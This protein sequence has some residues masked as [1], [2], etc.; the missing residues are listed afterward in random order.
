MTSLRGYCAMVEVNERNAWR[1]K[2]LDV[3]GRKEVTVHLF[4]MFNPLVYG[5]LFKG[6]LI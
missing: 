1:N 4:Q 5:V 3:I 2:S 6:H